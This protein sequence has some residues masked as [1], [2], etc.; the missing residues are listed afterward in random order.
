MTNT[1][2]TKTSKLRPILTDEQYQAGLDLEHEWK[3]GKLKYSDLELL[4]EVPEA[5]TMVREQISGWEKASDILDRTHNEEHYTVLR[6]FP[7]NIARFIYLELKALIF[8]TEKQKLVRHLYRLNGYLSY[9]KPTEFKTSGM[10]NKEIIE[11]ANNTPF[12]LSAGV[13]T[14]KGSK[15]FNLTSKFKNC[16]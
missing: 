13:W 3:K 12:G 4:T 10:M 14:D 7:D 5:E 16:R 15:V 2:R 9:L 11:K 8:K 1:T 6:D